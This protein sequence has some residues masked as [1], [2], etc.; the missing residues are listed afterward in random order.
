LYT[1]IG[2]RVIDFS[3]AIWRRQS[4]YVQTRRIPDAGDIRH[5]A[6]KRAWPEADDCNDDS[7]AA[8]IWQEALQRLRSAVDCLDPGARDFWQS[9]ASGTALDDIACQLGISYE[10][11]RG[12]RQRLLAKLKVRL[13]DERKA[14]VRRIRKN[15][16]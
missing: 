15:H 12:Q 8:L 10:Q 16:L 3:R 7:L 13:C 6:I 11:A 5:G 4:H 1:V 9:L 2:S 14:P